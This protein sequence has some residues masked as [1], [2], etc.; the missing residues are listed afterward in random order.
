MEADDLDYFDSDDIFEFLS[1]KETI[2]VL[3]AFKTAYFDSI[4]KRVIQ[5][6]ERKMAQ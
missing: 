2:E 1:Y 5:S 4:K 3:T 6:K